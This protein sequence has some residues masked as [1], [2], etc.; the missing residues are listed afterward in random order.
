MP[1]GSDD[2]RTVGQTEMIEDLHHDLGLGEEGEQ[3]AAPAAGIA[4]E[5]VEGEDAE[6]E[7]GP[8]EAASQT[9][10]GTRA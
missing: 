6:K 9:V 4:A 2:R 7:R 5:H 8:V 3:A 1:R 10:A